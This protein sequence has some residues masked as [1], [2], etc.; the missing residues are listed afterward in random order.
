MLNEQKTYNPLKMW[1]SWIGAIGLYL[2]LATT[3]NPSGDKFTIIE[4]MVNS[5]ST[6][7]AI[8][9]ILIILVTG[10]FIGWGIHSLIR[11]IKSKNT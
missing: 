11:K 6:P 1:G 9:F 7:I 8:L 5:V 10:F 3:F 2:F 4:H